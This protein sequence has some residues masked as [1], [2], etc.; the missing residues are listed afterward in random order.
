MLFC[1]KCG[2]K[3][4]SEAKFCVCCGTALKATMNV[5]TVKNES[6]IKTNSNTEEISN[7]WVWALVSFQMCMIYSRNYFLGSQW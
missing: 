5:A 4:K 2:K 7:K 6:T 3:L 1:T